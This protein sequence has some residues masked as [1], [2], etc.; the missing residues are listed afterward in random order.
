MAAEMVNHLLRLRV[1]FFLSKLA[2]DRAQAG[3]DPPFGRSEVQTLERVRQANSGG[4]GQTVAVAAGCSRTRA[5]TRSLGELKP[6]AT[7]C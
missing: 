5:R 2:C 1:P 7:L 3:P 6:G 4:I